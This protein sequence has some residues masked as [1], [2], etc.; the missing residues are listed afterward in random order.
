M[1]QSG[2]QRNHRHAKV[3]ICLI[4]YIWRVILKL[5]NMDAKQAYDFWASLYDSNKNNTR[6]LEA[7]ALR[8]MLGKS[9]FESCLEIGC[10]TGKNTE[11]LVSKAKRVTAVDFSSEM[12]AKAQQKV[13]ADNVT[14]INAD[15]SLDWNFVSPPY[16][17]VCFSLVLEHIEFLHPVFAKAA[18]ALSP[19]GCLYMGELHPFKQYTGTKARFDTE[20]GRQIVDC[21]NHHV[22]DFAESAAKAGLSMIEFKEY[23]D[24]PERNEIPRILAIIFQ[25]PA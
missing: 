24:T 11:W 9:S 25:K 4:A 21:Y 8:E 13:K 5:L 16:D 19:G 23:F 3:L 14:F 1:I 18:E 7:K 2:S 6:D 17:L 15:I 12:L 22:S 10:G 20:A